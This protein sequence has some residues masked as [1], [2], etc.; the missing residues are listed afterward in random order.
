MAD[1]PQ[2]RGIDTTENKSKLDLFSVDQSRIPNAFDG[3]EDG[4]RKELTQFRVRKPGKSRLFKSHPDP[5]YRLPLHIIED[6]SGMK[7]QVYLVVGAVAEDLIEE[8]KP[9]LLTLCIDKMGGPF[10]MAGAIYGS[11]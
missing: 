1:A 11:K 10:F 4:I 3:S 8:T 6:D 2:I 9:N 5:A 7:K